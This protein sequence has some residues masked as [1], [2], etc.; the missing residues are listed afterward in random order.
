MFS[1]HSNVIFFHFIYKTHIWASACQNLQNGICVQQSQISLGIS[2][3]WSESLLCAQWVAKDPSFLLHVNSED[4]W[5]D[6]VDA[7]ADLS[8][9][10]AHMPFCRF[11]H[12]FGQLYYRKDAAWS[13]FFSYFSLR[14]GWYPS[15]C[16][17]CYYFQ[18]ISFTYKRR[19]VKSV[20]GEWIHFKPYTPIVP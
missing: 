9:R 3:V 8:L 1:C 7:Q 19:I 17:R 10:W 12:A 11:C 14:R 5:S 20:S 16:L 2:P 4:L 15:I 18:S 6:W 13:E